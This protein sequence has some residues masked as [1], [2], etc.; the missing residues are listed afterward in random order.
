MNTRDEGSAFLRYRKP[1]VFIRKYMSEELIYLYGFL[2]KDKPPENV[3]YNKYLMEIPELQWNPNPSLEDIIAYSIYLALDNESLD[4]A[5]ATYFD[6]KRNY[7]K[8]WY[9]PI[10]EEMT[11]KI[12][13]KNPESLRHYAEG[14]QAAKRYEKK[15][16]DIKQCMEETA[17]IIEKWRRD[18]FSYM[19]DFFFCPDKPDHSIARAFLYDV[20]YD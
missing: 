17:E 7:K 4:Q 9:K 13:V 12:S 5:I 6:K 15:T 18:K 14:I 8:N 2:I 20:T 1:A 16:I 19:T 10:H 3:I 11:G